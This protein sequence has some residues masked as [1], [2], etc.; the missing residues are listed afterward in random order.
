MNRIVILINRFMY[1]LL[2]SAYITIANAAPTVVENPSAYRA[3]KVKAT[4]IFVDT[5][6]LKSERIKAYPR[7]GY[8][9]EK[10][11]ERLV[12]IGL[13]KNE[14]D[15]IRLLALQR[16]RYDLKYFDAVL[17]I[18]DDVNDGG[19]LLNAGLINDISR[20]TTF[21]HSAEI[22]QRLQH[23]LRDR[24]KDTRAQV[25]L[26]AYYALVPTHDVVSISNLVESLRTGN[27]IPIPI[28]NAIELLDVDGS[29]K[30]IVT[31][32]PYLN[33]QDPKIQAQA[34]RALAIDAKSRKQI[35]ALVTNLESPQVVRENA[36][37][38]L[39]REDEE[40]F[41]Y[42]LKLLSNKGNSPDIRLATMR[43]SMGRINYHK[44]SS[45]LQVTFTRVV[46]NL[47]EEKGLK[48]QKGVDLTA[49]ARHLFLH[50]RK[51]VPAVRKSIGG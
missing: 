49:E 39:A 36:I 32:R 15:Q 34:A 1:A 14:D 5:N 42:A 17:K 26:A 9:D 41:S 29:A 31:I 38:A 50:M 10:T 48:T 45:Q 28:H 11:F 44:V 19:E 22:R 4:E 7:L 33:N 30:H 16:A 25:R 8:P 35:I 47:S 40:F 27:N 23:A 2:I 3:E 20:R 24:L 18:L 13:D 12:Q 37:R 21:R 43:A 51:R 46:K 6:K